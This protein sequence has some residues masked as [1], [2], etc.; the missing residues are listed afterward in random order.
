MFAPLFAKLTGVRRRLDVPRS[1]RLLVRDKVAV[2]AS[3][4][5]ILQW[6]FT[7]VLVA[8]NS[9]VASG[10]HAA[11]ARALRSLPGSKNP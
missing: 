7:R 5:Q 1:V 6:P 11:V 4:A 10:A 3:A 8:H 9:V 2:Q